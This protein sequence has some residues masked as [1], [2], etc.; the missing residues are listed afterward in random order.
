M[1]RYT[2]FRFFLCKKMKKMEKHHVLYIPSFRFSFSDSII[3]NK[4][5]VIKFPLPFS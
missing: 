1:I 3:E 5:R 4:I 2:Y